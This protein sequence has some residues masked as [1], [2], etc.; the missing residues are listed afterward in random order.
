MTSLFGYLVERSVRAPSV[1]TVEQRSDAPATAPARQ[2]EVEPAL[3]GTRGSIRPRRRTR[4]ERGPSPEHSVGETLALAD[5]TTR[6][7]PMDVRARVSEEEND[8]RGTTGRVG[9]P[10]ARAPAETLRQ[11]RPASDRARERA[12]VGSAPRSLTPISAPL[13]PGLVAAADAPKVS[14]S[15]DAAADAEP[16]RLPTGAPRVHAPTVRSVA[17]VALTPAALPDRSSRD[18]NELARHPRSARPSIEPVPAPPSPP[19]SIKPVLAPPSP[20]SVEPAMPQSGDI[21]PARQRSRLREAP[22]PS[23]LARRRPP[24]DQPAVPSVQ[25][26]IGRVEVRAVYAPPP[27]AARRPSP[28][29]TMSLDDYLKQREKG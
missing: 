10:M 9:A 28:A 18:E 1:A 13:P 29:P 24:A 12:P 4:Y 14:S 17:A 27:S 8:V 23:A 20:P 2:S 5:E 25:V 22:P 19:S 3:D 26:S 21:A 15:N 11:S 16:S 6:L 7:R